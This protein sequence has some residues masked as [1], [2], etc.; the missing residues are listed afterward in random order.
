MALLPLS[1]QTSSQ[2]SVYTY[3]SNGQRVPA[4]TYSTIGGPTGSER[5]QTTRNINGRT[6]PVQSSQDKVISQSGNTKVIERTVTNYDTNGRPV[7]VDRIRIEETKRPDG[8]STVTTA[9]F[10]SDIN[11]NQQLV[12]RTSTDVK[13]SGST[14]TAVTSIERPGA[15]GTLELAEKKNAVTQKSANGAKV[16]STV[17]RRDVNGS[18]FTAVSETSTTTKSGNVESVDTAQYVRGPDGRMELDKRVVGKTTTRADGGQVEQ[19]EIYAKMN[20][21]NAGDLNAQQP[22]LQQ[23]VTRERV[24]GPNNTIVETTSIRA[25][26]PNDPSRFTNYEK[27]QQVIQQSQNA[28][29]M[30]V[31]NQRAVV[32]RRDVNGNLIVEKETL[33]NSVAPKPVPQ[34]QPQ[35]QAVPPAK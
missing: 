18:L 22:R 5:V 20:A 31:T 4:G 32:E 21:S 24:P 13:V 7:G 6:V 28:A 30:I 25:R 10:K 35:A 8:S 19:V 2:T 12:E 17:Y 11:G 23:E 15:N 34:P 9:T 29:G 3:D 14:E 16:E 26:V 33:Q 27:T 1:A